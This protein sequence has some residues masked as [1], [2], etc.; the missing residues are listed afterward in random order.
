MHGEI[1]ITYYDM[2]HSTNSISTRELQTH[3][4]VI[5]FI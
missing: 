1:L 4:N 2:N 5:D 3:I